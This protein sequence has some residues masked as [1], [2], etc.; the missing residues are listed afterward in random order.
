[1]ASLPTKASLEEEAKKKA[2]EEKAKLPIFDNE[3][4]KTN[5]INHLSKNEF[6]GSK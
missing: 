4:F 2:E 6:G 5:F 3:Y 1:M